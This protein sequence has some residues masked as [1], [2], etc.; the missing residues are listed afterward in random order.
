MK[1]ETYR[2]PPCSILLFIIFLV[3][4]VG[5][6]SCEAIEKKEVIDLP[7]PKYSG[8]TAIEEALLK[9]KSV[10]NYTNETLSLSDV[11]QLLWSAQGITRSGVF[12]TAP[13][14]GALY[15]LEVYIVA[16]DVN[17]LSAGIYK[18]SPQK[19]ELIQIEESD[20]RAELAKAAFGQSWVEDGA[21]VM[22]FA[23]VFAR[24]KQKYGGRGSQYVY[25]EA[26]AASENV[27][28]Q[29]VSLNL[30]T[31]SVGAFD[32]KR[33]K[34]LLRMRPDEDPIL[35]MPIGKSK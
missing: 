24:T 5:S 7:D 31:V 35:I 32:D 2:K 19:H 29:V 3:V 33:V 8:K 6:N 26:G 16:G 34:S 17:N 11:S 4:I 13:S 28:L 25:I 18:Y 30:A 22:V 21:I 14:A 15:P 9:R 27:Y 1:K 10:R 12:R 23:G 20:K